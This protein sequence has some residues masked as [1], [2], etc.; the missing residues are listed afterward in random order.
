MDRGKR[1]TKDCPC[2]KVEGNK[3]ISSNRTDK[4]KYD[5]RK[6]RREYCLG[7]HVKKMF[8]GKG[9]ICVK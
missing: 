6:T 5:R 2:F 4:D 7:R 9:L 8:S 1:R 3:K